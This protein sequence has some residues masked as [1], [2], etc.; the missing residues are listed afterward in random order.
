MPLASLSGKSRSSAAFFPTGG[1]VESRRRKSIRDNS[2][3]GRE[4]IAVVGV[5]GEALGIRLLL[6]VGPPISG[7]GGGE[8]RRDQFPVQTQY[9]LPPLS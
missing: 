1:E 5:L 9:R 2:N 8:R 4:A 7:G 6:A 3:L